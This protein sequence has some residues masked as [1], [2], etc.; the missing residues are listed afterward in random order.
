MTY[1]LTST[2]S[3]IRTEDGAFIP[4]K[5]DNIDYQ[6]YI[7]W[8]ENGNKPLPAD[9]ISKPQELTPEQ[10]LNASGLTVDELKKLLGLS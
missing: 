10:K 5:A 8:L 2:N 4:T 1:Q 7:R 3:I 6:E 9:V